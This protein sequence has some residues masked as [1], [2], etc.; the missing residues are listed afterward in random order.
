[1]GSSPTWGVPIFNLMSEKFQIPNDQESEGIFLKGCLFAMVFNFI[2]IAL[3]LLI[4]N[5]FH[6]HLLAAYG[7]G[8]VF[9]CLAGL[10]FLR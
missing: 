1:M 3:T 6:L 10:R 4:V 2:L 9:M 5:L 8:L 7:I